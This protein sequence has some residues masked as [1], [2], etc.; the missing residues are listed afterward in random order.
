MLTIESSESGSPEPSPIST[1]VKEYRW[2]SWPEYEGRYGI[3][4][5]CDTRAVMNR[6][7]SDNVYE[8]V[9]MPV[10]DE[11]PDV[12]NDTKSSITDED[13]KSYVISQTHLNTS[14]DVSSLSKKERNEVIKLLCE[15]GASLRQISR[16]TGVPYGIV[17]RINRKQ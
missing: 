16:V 11:I 6:L 17:Y 1:E 8:Y 15:H 7:D 3:L 13:L 5:I 2:S 9:T 10:C 4:K 12:D 14:F